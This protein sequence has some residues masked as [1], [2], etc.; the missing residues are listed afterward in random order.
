MAARSEPLDSALRTLLVTMT[1]GAFLALLDTTMTGVGIDTLVREFGSTLAAIQ[2]VT[3]AYLL[4]VSVTAPLSGWAIDRF[5]ARRTWL[6]GLSVFVL[7]SLASCLAWDAPSLI[8]TRL[9]TGLGGGLLEPVMLATLARA[10][11]QQRVGR[12]LGLAAAPMTM[13][14]VIGP[15]LGGLLLQA[16]PWQWI[17]LVKVPVGALAIVLAV[18]LMPAD[19]TTTGEAAK[20]LDVLGVMLLPPGFAALMYALANAVE[21]VTAPVLIAGALGAMLFAGYAAHA[22][23]TR[24]EPLIDLRLFRSSGFAAS[25]SVL[26]LIGAIMFGTTFL[27]PLHFQQIGGHGVMAAGLLLAPFGLGAVVAQPTAGRLSDRTGARLPATVGGLLLIPGF[28]PYALGFTGVVATLGLVVVGF[29]LGVVASTT[30]GSVYRTVPPASASRATGAL[31]IV[32]QIGGAL[33]ITL[34]TLV[35]Q[36]ATASAPPE[37]A[38]RTTFWWLVGAGVAMSAAARILPG[39]PASAAPT[40]ETAAVAEHA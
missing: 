33:G 34:L 22:L 25:V 7:G 36:S 32:H 30:M 3:T 24:R 26:F 31:F 40:T 12:V 17:F 20:R 16:L 19:D 38:F 2:W 15:V 18:R 1:L 8:A 10:A 11:G 37:A 29:G 4:A 23:T 28:L 9:L 13:G 6:A 39:R 27:L 21:G 35:L 14:P 5:G